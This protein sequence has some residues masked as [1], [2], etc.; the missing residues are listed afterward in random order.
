MT[1][2][3]ETYSLSFSPSSLVVPTDFD[4]SNPDLKQ[5][6]SNLSLIVG[7]D[8]IDFI[9]GSVEI[10]ENG[11]SVRNERKPDMSYDF[12]I[13]EIPTSV[14]SF[15]LTVTVQYMA[16]DVYRTAIARLNVTTV[17]NM[18]GIKWIQDW[19]G[20]SSI[21]ADN[22]V[23]SPKIFVGHK[24]IDK[25]TQQLKLTGIYL[26]K[27]KGFIG[28]TLPYVFDDADEG[29]YG[30]RENKIVFYINNH[31]AR[32]AG[33]DMNHN[34]ITT[35]NEKGSVS[36]LS[37][38]VLQYLNAKNEKVWYLESDGSAMF[39]KG[40][41]KIDA[42]G[43]AY[44]NG[45]IVTKKG[46]VIAGWSITDGCIYSKNMRLDSAKNIIGVLGGE[47]LTGEIASDEYFNK[48][49]DKGGVIMQYNNADSYGIIGT[50]P[51]STGQP[52]KVSFQLGKINKI[53]GWSFDDSALW[54]GTKKDTA[55][56]FSG[57]TG[58]L[59][60]G[61]NGLRGVN[62]YI[63]NNGNASFSGGLFTFTNKECRLAGW[64][65]KPNELI[66]NGITLASDETNMGWYIS[67]TILSDGINDYAAH[68]QQKGGIYAKRVQNKGSELVGIKSVGLKTVFKLSTDETSNIAGW[69]FDH[70]AIWSGSKVTSS[71]SYAT[72]GITIHSKYGI[73]SKKIK[74]LSDGSGALAGGNIRWTADG[75]VTFGTNVALSWDNMPG[76]VKGRLT[77]ITAE[78]I[79][80]GTL[81]AN[82][83]T[84]GTI[85]TA[86]IKSKSNIWSLNNDGSGYLANNNISWDAKGNVRFSDSV[87]M[88]W[89]EGIS[90][91]SIIATGV[92]LHRDPEFENG[93]NGITKYAVADGSTFEVRKVANAP[94]RSG[95]MLHIISSKW[96]DVSN[97]RCGGFAL[98]DQ[99]K[100]G[101]MFV[102]RIV[103]SFPE[104]WMI[105]DYH[106]Q[107]G[108][109]GKTA[110][111]TS[112]MGTGHF[113]E[114]ICLVRCG[115][116]G[117]FSLINH[118][119]LVYKDNDKY[120]VVKPTA[121]DPT[122]RIKDKSTGTVTSQTVNFIVA[123]ANTFDG[124]ASEGF[125][126]TITK[127]G[128][129]TGTIIAS[130][131]TSGKISASHIDVDSV[132]KHSGGKWKLS[133]DGSG[134]LANNKF[135]WDAAGNIVCNTGTFNQ[136]TVNNGKFDDVVINNSCS[137]YGF[138]GKQKLIIT[139]GNI[140]QYVTSISVAEGVNVYA[141]LFDKIGSFIDIYS[142]GATLP[143]VS[144]LLSIELPSFSPGHNTPSSK[145]DQNFKYVGSEILLYCHNKSGIIITGNL[146][147]EKNPS[148]PHSI[149]LSPGEY[150]LLRCKFRVTAGG[151][152]YWTHEKFTL[153]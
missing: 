21:V 148:S 105:A 78:G 85:S 36:I 79:Y 140:N 132:L 54:L 64:I 135:K 45:K 120:E 25:A 8:N 147:D 90:A 53:G 131:I 20:T 150:V 57:G 91:S 125:L 89:G 50:L 128:I 149:T 60:I 24:E 9:I 40:N 37:S 130:Q 7:C 100:S 84:S 19:S 139:D 113:Q 138:I 80:T 34:G 98:G 143:N 94:N 97:M 81:S 111:I 110:W 114:Y 42:E 38:G 14:S 146:F 145:F 29:F 69:N 119:A 117:T 129:Y 133:S 103:A 127:D 123:Y 109:G 136:I 70:E 151:E 65:V 82:N 31:G 122:I 55:G 61:K 115:Y 137:F 11:V 13:T 101:G 71:N 49:M 116:S 58:N 124:T 12:Y 107:F 87:K 144:G 17:R 48:V 41:V 126:T 108:D 1:V 141:F 142:D 39:G 106:N 93:L 27:L 72:E 46:S 74:L 68:I 104:N 112:R 15:V 62:W 51:R 96:G 83:I 16:G 66:S 86:T 56:Q 152:I 67:K 6:H 2:L 4:G 22:Y 28:Q 43:N 134:W 33:W 73:Y 121:S 23:I 88:S 63:D 99:S 18:D 30:Y 59:T 76:D 5:A 92:Q 102:V 52:I 75:N 3:N 95:K 118:F 153:T 47:P 10:S 35:K 26:G 77:K 32:I 44:F